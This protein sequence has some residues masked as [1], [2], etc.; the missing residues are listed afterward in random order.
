MRD[1][2]TKDMYY[3][4]AKP[5]SYDHNKRV[6]AKTVEYIV[7]HNTNKDKDGDTAKNNVDYFAT[8]NI[9]EAGAHFF[10]DQ[11]GNIGRSIPMDYTAWAV[12]GKGIG[13]MKGI[14]RNDNSVSIE[15]CSIAFKDPSDAM[16][17]SL[18]D[19]IRYI[20]KYCPKV[21]GIV[22]HFDVT[23]KECPARMMDNKKWNEFLTRIMLTSISR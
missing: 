10:V 3:R 6:K 16:V 15:L 19:L 4:K 8:G 1:L 5:I 20:Y 21:K 23:G 14:V 9:Y 18:I 7:I 11:N 12:G 17:E 22:R 2:T 13:T